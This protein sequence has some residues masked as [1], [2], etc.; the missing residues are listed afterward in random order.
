[1]IVGGTRELTDNV[2]A[3]RIN[4]QLSAL[5]MK[6]KAATAS[7]TVSSVLPVLKRQDM[8]HLVDIN[9]QMKETCDE[10]QV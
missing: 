8:Q 4:E 1:M 9:R 10:L 5:V 2:S 3:E 6:A 7:V